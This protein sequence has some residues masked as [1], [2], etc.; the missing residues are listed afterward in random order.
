ME[1]HKQNNEMISSTLT[2]TTMSLSQLQ[3]SFANVQSQLKMEKVSSLAK[4]NR[5]KSLEGLV[6]KIGYDTKDVNATNE[7]IKKKKLDITTLRKQLKLATLEDP[8]T[9]E[10]VEYEALK[11]DMMK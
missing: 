1:M 6:I 2:T 11:A 3:V 10:I 5:I 7:I 9:K 8:M 4:E